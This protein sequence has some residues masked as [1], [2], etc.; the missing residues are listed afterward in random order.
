[1][2]KTRGCLL[3]GLLLSRKAAVAVAVAISAIAEL[4]EHIRHR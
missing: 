2:P 3:D 4:A 1:V